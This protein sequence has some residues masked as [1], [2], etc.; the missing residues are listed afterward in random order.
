MVLGDGQTEIEIYRVDQWDN[1]KNICDDE[2]DQSELSKI[3]AEHYQCH[4]AI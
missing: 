3:L 1:L 4:L 2:A